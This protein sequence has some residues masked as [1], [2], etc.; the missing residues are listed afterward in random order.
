ML[1]DAMPLTDGSRTNVLPNPYF[2]NTDLII[3]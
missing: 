1:G 2:G 3:L